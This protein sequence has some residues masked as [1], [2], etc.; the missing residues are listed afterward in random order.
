MRSF[1]SALRSLFLAMMGVSWL[2]SQQLPDEDLDASET[3]AEQN[4]ERFELK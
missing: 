4:A 3:D 1:S 2:R